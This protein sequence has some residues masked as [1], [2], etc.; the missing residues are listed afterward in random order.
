MA[1][2]AG[3]T[4][5][6]KDLG[7]RLKPEEIQALGTDLSSDAVL[8]RSTIRQIDK[9]DEALDMGLTGRFV[10]DVYVDAAGKVTSAELSKKIGYGMDRLVLQAARRA[11]FKPRRN[12][13]GRPMPG[14]TTIV[15]R[16]TEE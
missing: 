5:M 7:I 1:A 10:V 11:R 8:I 15:F 9:T 13:K 3:N 4:T 14:W 6:T 16:F 2:P 12:P